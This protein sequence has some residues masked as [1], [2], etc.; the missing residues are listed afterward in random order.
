MDHLSRICAYALI[1]ATFSGCAVATMP[2]NPNLKLDLQYLEQVGAENH[3]YD[4]YA[5]FRDTR[6]SKKYN[7]YDSSSDGFIP[8]DK[9]VDGFVET[10]TA[11]RLDLK[12]VSYN[13]R[14]TLTAKFIVAQ[15]EFLK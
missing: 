9:F 6:T 2:G 12:N 10:D 15:Q 5:F 11:K 1:S 7:L 13:L 8:E 3:D 14:K 4:H